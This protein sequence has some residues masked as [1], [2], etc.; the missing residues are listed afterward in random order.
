MVVSSPSF[1]HCYIL[2][3]DLY[4]NTTY[5]YSECRECFGD[6]E[7]LGI[8]QKKPMRLGGCNRAYYGIQKVREDMTLRSSLVIGAWRA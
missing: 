7:A 6:L 5:T 3:G 1:S 4:S 2:R 8:C